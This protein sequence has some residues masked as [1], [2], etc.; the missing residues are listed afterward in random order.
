[1][2]KR[3]IGLGFRLFPGFVVLGKD[4]DGTFEH[5]SF[6]VGNHGGMDTESAGD[7]RHCFV[8]LNGCSSDLC[9]ELWTVCFA[10]FTHCQI[11]LNVV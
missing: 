8:V 10:F 3:F 11:L 6:P 2:A 5:L 7:L 1:M 4:V 9:L